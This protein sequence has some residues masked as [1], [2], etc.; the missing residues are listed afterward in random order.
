MH[1]ALTNDDLA[2]L[3]EPAFRHVIREWVEQNYPA[4]LRHRP[5][6][7]RWAEAKP[8]YLKLSER[9]WLAPRWPR[10]HGGMALPPALQIV[11]IEELERHGVARLP[12]QGIINLGP[13]LIQHGAQ[14]QKRHFLPKILSGEH[15]WCQGYSEP[16][17]GSDLA[18]LRT[19]AV[20]EGNNWI[21]NGQKIWTTLA[22][23][24]NWIYLLVRTD[25]TARKHAGISFLLVPMDSRGITVRPIR[26]IDLEEEF[27]EVFF[28]VPRDNL[29]GQINAG[30]DIAKSLL[31]FERVFVGAPGQSE[32]A[33]ARLEALAV[34]TGVWT[35][36]SFS[37]RY[38][39]LKMDFED[40]QALFE[41]YL[42]LLRRGASIGPEV[43]ILK[44]IRVNCSSAS[45]MPCS[46]FPANSP[47][48]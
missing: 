42:G 12:D 10:E 1:H 37:E 24:A 48:A 3:D 46:N 2:A 21:V 9:G 19:S 20:L 30:W 29:V 28:E 14:A 43:S 35:D 17:A 33:L 31:G 8:W 22:A 32:A 7:L 13:M 40:H 45:P 15:V 23:D 39:T 11:M 6:R 41:H 25:P 5:Q 44:F 38:I 26:S 16:N 18:S 36:L 27:C 47:A 34:A 4:E